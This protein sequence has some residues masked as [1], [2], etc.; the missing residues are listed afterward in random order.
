VMALGVYQLSGGGGGKKTELPKYVIE[1][2]KIKNVDE[3]LAKISD[4]DIIKFL[5]ANGTDVDAALVA[6]KMDET[7]LPSQEDYLS[8][9]KALDKFLD[10]V[11]LNDLKN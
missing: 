11:D 8:D 10:N 5:Q 9:D 2:K 7:E 1:G 4:D 6:N 3:E